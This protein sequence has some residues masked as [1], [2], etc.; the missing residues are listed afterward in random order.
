MSVLRR[1][2]FNLWVVAAILLLAVILGVLNNLRVYEDQRAPWPWED[3]DFEEG[4]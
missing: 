2:P 4:E 1:M 3:F